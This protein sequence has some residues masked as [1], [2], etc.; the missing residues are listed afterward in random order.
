MKLKQLVEISYI[1]ICCNKKETRRLYYGLILVVLIIVVFGTYLFSINSQKNGFMNEYGQAC[2]VTYVFDDECTYKDIQEKKENFKKDMGSDVKEIS[3]FGDVS[4]EITNNNVKE[5][6]KIKMKIGNKNFKVD[7][8]ESF[9]SAHPYAKSW[10]NINIYDSDT[11]FFP[12]TLEKKGMSN[13]YYEGELPKEKGEI[14]LSDYFLQCMGVLQ[15]EQTDLI[16]Q[17]ITLCNR[18]VTCKGYK[19]S[20]IFYA[21]KL[22]KRES[23]EMLNKQFAQILINFRLDDAKKIR[24]DKLT[25]RCYF[26][27]YEQYLSLKNRKKKIVQY[28]GPY[29]TKDGEVYGFMNREIQLFNTFLTYISGLAC[30]SILACLFGVLHFFW[31]NN[32]RRSQ[33]FIYLGMNLKDIYKVYGLEIL[34]I[35][36]PAVMIGGYLGVLMLLLLNILY[37]DI[38]SMPLGINP[39]IICS[40]ILGGGSVLLIIM[41]L[42]LKIKIATMMNRLLK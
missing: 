30:V 24:I 3:S 12:T 34:I 10:S 11:N 38:V 29:Y 31:I 13:I 20:G 25:Y 16:G 23:A 1:C 32:F 28:E 8:A 33:L 17:D 2:Y 18:G 41:F 4:L 27:S 14:F 5:N 35:V 15:E 19:L 22:E 9:D 37:R 26:S 40:L 21:D 6:N 39:T 36:I 42:V 7:A